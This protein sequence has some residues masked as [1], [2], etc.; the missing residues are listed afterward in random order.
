MV[1]VLFVEGFEEIKI[2]NGKNTILV[3]AETSPEDIE[4]VFSN[5]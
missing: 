2:Q 5:A 4:G 3:R 1:Y